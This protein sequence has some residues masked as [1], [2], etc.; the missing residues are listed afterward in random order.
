MHLT[1][2]LQTNGLVDGL[3]PKGQP[4]PF[5]KA[6]GLVNESCPTAENPNHKYNYSCAAARAHSMMT[7]SEN[8][9]LRKIVGKKP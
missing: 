3:I 7:L 5:L 8:S 9:L 1:P 6:C 4:C 2:H